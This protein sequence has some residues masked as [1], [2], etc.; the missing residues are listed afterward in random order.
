MLNPAASEGVEA[1]ELDSPF[2]TLNWLQKHREVARS[3][4]LGV[5]GVVELVLRCVQQD[6]EPTRKGTAVAFRWLPRELRFPSLHQ[7]HQCLFLDAR[8]SCRIGHCREDP[9]GEEHHPVVPATVQP[10]S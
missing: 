2:P 8:E 5:A 10:P 1:A 4:R 9:T 7:R 3:A 6:F